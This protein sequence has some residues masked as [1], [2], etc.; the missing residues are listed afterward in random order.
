[1]LLLNLDRVARVNLF[2]DARDN[3]GG[4]ASFDT[5]DDEFADDLARDGRAM[6]FD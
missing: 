2:R 5:Q 3:G 4:R 1:M 6:P